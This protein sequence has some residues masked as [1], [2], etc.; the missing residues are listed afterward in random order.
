STLDPSPP[1]VSAYL[2]RRMKTVLHIVGARPN[3]MRV[4]PIF[5]AISERGK[6]RQ[7]L[8]HTGQHYDVKMSDVFFTDLGMPP[9]DIHLGVGSGSHA[10][11]TAKVMLALE[12]V[13]AA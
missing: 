5:K 10:E 11:Q 8:V 7:L 3:F 2:S 9:P 6:L 4:A 13:F 1:R 12:K